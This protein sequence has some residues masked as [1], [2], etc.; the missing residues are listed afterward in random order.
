MPTLLL[1]GEADAVV[2]PAYAL[3]RRS[4]PDSADPRWGGNYWA[5]R[6]PDPAGQAGLFM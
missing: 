6:I 4:L 5:V 3:L 2:P 1:G